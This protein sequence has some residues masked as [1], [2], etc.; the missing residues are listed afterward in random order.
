MLLFCNCYKTVSGHFFATCIFIFH[1]TEVQAIILRCL[2]CL[3]EKQ[4][5]ISVGGF[6]METSNFGLKGCPRVCIDLKFDAGS[7]VVLRF[8]PSAQWGPQFRNTCF[9]TSFSTKIWWIFTLLLTFF[10]F[11]WPLCINVSI[12]IKLALNF[13]FFET[14]GSCLGRK[15]EVLETF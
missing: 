14:L 5:W 15:M 10:A 9:L 12:P 8:M 13:W 2:M 7:N 1:K 6:G 11:F 3:K 4:S